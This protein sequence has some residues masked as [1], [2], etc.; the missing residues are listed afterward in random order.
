[1]VKKNN[2]AD[3]LKSLHSYKKAAQEVDKIQNN[4]PVVIT[5]TNPLQ[6]KAMLNMI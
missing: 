5:G 1:M 3:I 6:H 4:H 2:T